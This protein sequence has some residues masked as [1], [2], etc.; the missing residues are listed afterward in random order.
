MLA[1]CS[2]LLADSM[3]EG[4]PMSA[5]FSVF[6]CKSL[7]RSASTRRYILPASF[8]GLENSAT[9]S[10]LNPKRTPIWEGVSRSLARGSA[11]CNN[12][13]SIFKVYLCSIIAADI[14]ILLHQDTKNLSVRADDGTFGSCAVSLILRGDDRHVYILAM[15]QQQ[16]RVVLT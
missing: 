3:A 14:Y 5:S 15:N 1:V 8:H 10:A 11:F 2:Q 16:L 9:S 13:F 12:S 4:E 7:A 6:S